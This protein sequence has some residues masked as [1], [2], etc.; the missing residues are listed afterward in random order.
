VVNVKVPLNPVQKRGLWPP[1]NAREYPVLDTDDW[2]IIAA[3][4]HLDVWELIKFNFATHVP[5]EVNWYLRELV[6]CRHSKDGRNYAF[7]GADKS[8]GK[9]YLP[10]APPAPAPHV[11][12]CYEKL[13]KLKYEVEHSNDPLKTRLLCMLDAMENRRDDRVIFWHDIAPD[14]NVVSPLGVIKANPLEKRFIDA[15][16]LYD[17]IKTWQ[18]VDALPLSNGI[19]SQSFVVSLHKF[20]C[21]TMSPGTMPP[22][23]IH[24]RGAHDSIV[25]THEMLYRWA[26][27]PLGGSSSM[28]VAYRAIQ[29]FVRLG[30]GSQGSVLRCIV[31]TGAGP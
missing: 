17:H 6:G 23:L 3:R 13:K 19:S 12:P 7:L 25:E 2:W 16:W 4:E 22:L 26:N 29:E 28:M 31:T 20:L 5:E 10:L 15:Q 1:K 30:E 24:L 9:I 21:E 18:D 14:D 11:E 8:K 27:V